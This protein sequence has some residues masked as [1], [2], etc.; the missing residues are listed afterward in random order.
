LNIDVV[1][2]F[3]ILISRRR[4]SELEVYVYI[5]KLDY[6]F[7][8]LGILS[9]VVAT[10]NNDFCSFSETWVWLQIC[11]RRGLPPGDGV[12]FY[13]GEV[14]SSS[15]EPVAS[16][17]LERILSG[18][19]VILLYQSM[20]VL[21]TLRAYSWSYIFRSSSRVLILKQDRWLS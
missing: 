7:V 17:R 3:N 1:R 18:M 14:F 13:P 5:W 21:I 2:Q 12:L 8:Q 19:Q 16:L 9:S 20:H 6:I 4:Y 11:F 15:H 10:L